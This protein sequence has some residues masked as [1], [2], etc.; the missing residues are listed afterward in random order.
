M[1]IVLNSNELVGLVFGQAQ[2]DFALGLFNLLIIMRVKADFLK[3]GSKS[4][5]VG[6]CVF[7]L[8]GN[9]FQLLYRPA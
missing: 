8:P 7:C 4:K 9:P 1:W 5:H 3:S 6:C 2:N